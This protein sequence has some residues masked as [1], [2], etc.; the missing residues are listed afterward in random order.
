VTPHPSA[1]GA[2]RLLACVMLIVSPCA[3]A[4][5]DVW[6]LLESGG[7]VVLMR[8]TITTPGIGDPPGFSIDDCSTQRNLTDEGRR[9]ARAIG[10]AFRARRIQVDRVL[11]SPWCRCLE[12]ARLAFGRAEVSQ[13]LS[14]LFGQ[15]A[16]TAEHIEALRALV[17]SHAGKGN[18]VLVTHSLT[19]VALTDVSTEPGEMVVVS[20]RPDGRFTVEGRLAI[21]AR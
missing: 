13:P 7:R 15:P 5:P 6:K 10:D 11:S 4:A 21:A 20:R 18:L 16:V 17:A 1:A 9:H 2:V 3:S 8:H 12:T 19:I 14:N